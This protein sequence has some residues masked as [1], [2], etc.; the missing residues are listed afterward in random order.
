MATFIKK[1]YWILLLV[2]ALAG[3]AIDGY[4]TRNGAGLTGDGFWYLQGA[5]NILGGHGYSLHRADGFIPIAEY[6]P[7]YSIVLAGLGIF[8]GAIYT[9]GRVLGIVLL[10]VNI[11]LVGWLIFR[12][13][14][15]PGWALTG[16]ALLLLSRDIL[17]VHAWILT[18]PLYITLTLACLI[19]ILLYLEE[20]RLLPLAIGALMAGLAIVT[21]YVGVAL[22]VL[23]CL[24]PLLF[25]Q[26]K[27]LSRFLQ[28]V[29]IGILGL[30]P[31]GIWS[32]R[33]ALLGLEPAGRS[34]IVVHALPTANL[35]TLFSSVWDWVFPDQTGL[36]R[37][38]RLILL[39]IALSLLLGVPL[40]DSLYK[41]KLVNRLQHPKFAQFIIALTLITILYI[42]VVFLSILFSLAGSPVNTAR[43]QISRYLIPAFAIFAVWA[44][45]GL[46]LWFQLLAPRN[47][48]KV[49][50][51]FAALYLIGLY[52]ITFGVF[53]NP[54]PLGYAD[55]KRN[56]PD[57]MA[58]LADVDPARPVVTNAYEEIYFLLGRPVYS[59]PGLTDELTGLPNPNQPMLM[60][61]TVT[62]IN[63]GA[64]VVIQRSTPTEKNFFD[65]LVSSLQLIGSYGQV[66]FYEK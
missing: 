44:S 62:L 57:L 64:L 66:T 9:I 16:S 32:L 21:R 47:V 43:T 22:L 40:Y 5:E 27:W 10:A 36:T 52:L 60:Q 7:L 53:H 33:N 18:E 8:G 34:G 55:V 6:P 14:R 59:I 38:P 31:V 35:V 63:Q 20:G 65:P 61:K 13:T 30:L 2:L 19:F 49:L 51:V 37:L 58:A 15:S 41:T 39:A 56:Q 3:A 23:C 45:L 50:P 54:I 48:L 29:G 1:Y 26:T 4:V 46:F 11:F 28:A 42:A 24:V 17:Y 12:L 25:E